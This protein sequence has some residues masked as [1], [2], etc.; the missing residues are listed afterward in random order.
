MRSVGLLAI[1]ACASANV[2]DLGFPKYISNCPN[3]CAEWTNA[4]N[5]NYTQ[6]AIDA[7]WEDASVQAASGANCAMPAAS[8]GDHECDCSDATERITDSFAG[9]WCVCKDPSTAGP[10]AAYCNAPK[11][12]PE[13][14][15]L[16]VAEPT[17]AVVGFVTYEDALPTNPPQAKFGNAGR[18]DTTTKLGVSH[19]Y[20]IGNR[21]WILSFIK[22]D[23]LEPKTEYSYSVKSGSND[24]AWSD[25][26]TF[27]SGY[28]SGVTRVATYG[29]MGHSHYNNMGNLK[30]DCEAGRIDAILHMGDHAYNF[31]MANGLRGDAYMNSY[32][33]VLSQCLWMP[34]IGNHEGSDGDHFNRYL[35]ITWGEIY[36]NEPPVHSTATSALGHLLSKGTMYAAGVHGPTPTFNSRYVSSNF[37]LI[38]MVGLDLNNL[39]DGQ[40]AWLEQDLAAAQANRQNV[41][42]IMV[43]SHF[44]IHHTDLYEHADA[45]AE[46]Y[47]GLEAETFATS[48]HDFK[49]CAKPGCKTVGEMATD[50]QKILHPIFVK[51]GVDIY[52]AGHIHDYQSMWPMCGNGT[53]CQND[54]INPKGPVHITEGN[55][56][57]PGVVGTNS[58]TPCTTPGGWCRMNGKG[59]AYARLTAWNY[60]HLTYEHVENPTGNV[61]DT[62][63]IVQ[64]NHGP[65]NASDHV[66]LK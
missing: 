24:C 56:G 23:G 20:T 2:Y 3:G 19:K 52:N 5:A 10:F 44:P 21:T 7:L 45:S 41:P 55:G 47:V 50:F 9:P 22:F 26:F 32:Q 1:V 46:Y 35:N 42:W 12:V 34:V 31:N 48:G 43:T 18:A 33:P 14:I 16:Q 54:F 66:F 25:T 64:A 58:V 17:V 61:S 13:Q 37:G 29:D 6:A 38:H 39:D 49:Q 28:A 59:G 30:A 63:T 53:A 36:G 57:V 27:R 40:V 11:A 65:F 60:T 8:A 15:N 4:A 62:W 51:Y